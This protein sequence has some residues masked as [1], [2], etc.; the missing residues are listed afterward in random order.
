MKS[1]GAVAFCWIDGAASPDENAPAKFDNALESAL[2]ESRK[3][4]QRIVVFVDVSKIQTREDSIDEDDSFFAYQFYETYFKNNCKVSNVQRKDYT[5]S[6]AQDKF[7]KCAHEFGDAEN[8]YLIDPPSEIRYDTDYTNIWVIRK[9]NKSGWQCEKIDS[10]LV[11]MGDVVRRAKLLAHQ[12]CRIWIS[13]ETGTGKSELARII[14]REWSKGKGKEYEDGKKFFEINIAEYHNSN[15]VTSQLFGYGP[16]SVTNGLKDGK[17]GIFAAA[18]K[19]VLF[20]DEVAECTSEVQAMLLSTL[21]VPLNKEKES[22]CS[23][24]RI[25]ENERNV[26]DVRLIFSTNKDVVKMMAEKTFRSDL[27]YRMAE[28]TIRTRSLREIREGYDGF[29]KNDPEKGER[30]FIQIVEKSLEKVNASL[31]PANKR[32]EFMK[33]RLSRSR[34][35][36]MVYWPKHLDGGAKAWL[37]DQD[38]SEGNARQLQIVL[39]R[40]CI[41]AEIKH[42]GTDTITEGIVKEAMEEIGQEMSDVRSFSARKPSLVGPEPLDGP[43]LV[44]QETSGLPGLEKVRQIKEFCEDKTCYMD[45]VALKEIVAFIEKNSA[46]TKKTCARELFEK[47]TSS[48]G[49]T[50]KKF[51][52]TFEAVKK[53]LASV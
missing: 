1:I 15:L 53:V 23:V 33:R 51:N 4:V 9:D 52:I 30:D 38:F 12:N 19:G 26:Y 40:A 36:G 34:E 49:R 21:S 8:V 31:L 24:Q 14:Y 41:N 20:V 35:G 16:G 18:D 29:G 2:K 45:K 27:Y 3:S 7:D 44:H 46:C 37:L 25:G 48:L 43:E 22:P 32:E 28:Y 39:R 13:G 17:I 6:T 47:S 42:Q 10:V 5:C 50:L 11:G